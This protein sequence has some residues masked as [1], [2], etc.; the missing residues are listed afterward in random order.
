MAQAGLGAL[1]LWLHLRGR[2][3]T[4]LDRPELPA[5]DGP[6]LIIC[7][8]DDLDR[9][10]EQVIGAM[11]QARPDLRVIRPGADGLPDF[12][13]DPTAAP[14]IIDAA[15]PAAVLLFGDALPPA[16]IDAAT[17]A[18]VPVILIEARLP[19]AG[20][21]WS[22]SG[23]MRRRL[24][25]LLSLV[26]VADP[27]CRGAVLDQ[28][29]PAARV[30]LT[31]PLTEIHD[32]LRC[33]EAERMAMAAMLRGRLVWLAAAVPQAEEQAVIEAHQ[34]ALRQSHRAV[35]IFVPNRPERAGALA[36]ALESA[37]LAVAQRNLEEDPVADVQ[38][39]VAEDEQEMGLWYRLAQVTYM[40][41]T[42]LGGNPAAR[43][44]FEPASL[45][46]AIIR[47][48]RIDVHETEWRH[49]D[50]AGA[51]R[52]V[53]NAA[54]LAEAVTDLSRPEL[55]ARLASNAWTVS[56]GGAGVARRIAQPILDLL[57]PRDAP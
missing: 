46:S 31:G 41:G 23:G 9:A 3:A 35:L 45:G 24:A 20:G 42:L 44:P 33:T 16:L 15:R 39:L 8:G 43:H 51:T 19:P 30:V 13:D 17:R 14:Q 12:A 27:P 26:T 21:W 29:V 10:A 5:G 2:P 11:R 56:T 32:P 4:R 40:G 25:G 6:L 50:G 55:A 28:G 54:A 47:G 36:E 18:G 57:P 22:L 1:G 38:V 53:R 48:P 34:A 7:V 52:A 49:L 37:G